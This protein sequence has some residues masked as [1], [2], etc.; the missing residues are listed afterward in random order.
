MSRPKKR[1]SVSAIF[2]SITGTKKE[3]VIVLDRKR[4]IYYPVKFQKTDQK[5]IIALIDSNNEVNVMSPVYN[6]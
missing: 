2:V 3:D 6:M 5:V 4:Y 1:A